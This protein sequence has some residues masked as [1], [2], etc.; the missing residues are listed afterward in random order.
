MSRRPAASSH[1]RSRAAGRSSS[2]SRRWSRRARS[3]RRGEP[4]AGW[5]RTGSRCSSRSSGRRAGIGLAS[6]DVYVNLAGGLS[7]GEPGLD[8]PIALALGSSLRDR[9]IRDRTVA[10]GEVGLLGELRSVTGLERRLREAARLGFQAGDRPARRPGRLAARTWPA[11]RSW[12]SSSLREAISATDARGSRRAC[13]ERPSTMLGWRPCR[14]GS[15][16]LYRSRE[17]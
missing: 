17:W 15:L 12:R 8:L 10:I 2:R 4:R 1:R 6:H 11:W 5:I 14:L 7:V 13:S 3:A 16:H 9:P